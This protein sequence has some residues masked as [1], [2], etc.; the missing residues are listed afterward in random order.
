MGGGVA[1]MVAA[2]TVLFYVPTVPSRLES[3]L[4]WLQLSQQ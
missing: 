3:L 1:V 2:E 4:R